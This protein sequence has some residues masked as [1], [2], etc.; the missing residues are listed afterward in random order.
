MIG[1][2]HLTEDHAM[3]RSSREPHDR[4]ESGRRP[5]EPPRVTFREPIEVITA[6]CDPSPFGKGDPAACPSAAPPQS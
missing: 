1:F 6:V 3:S 5:Y 2:G 4:P